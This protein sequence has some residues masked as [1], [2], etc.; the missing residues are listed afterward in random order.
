MAQLTKITT[1]DITKCV[2]LILEQLPEEVGQ[3][4]TFLS[5]DYKIPK[6]QLVCGVLLESQLSGRLSAFML[7]P[8]W[9]EGVKQ[10]TAI[11]KQCHKTFKPDRLGQIYCTEPCAQAAH[12][13]THP[14]LKESPNDRVNTVTI[15]NP[16]RLGGSDTP[17]PTDGDSGWSEIP[18]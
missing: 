10:T 3:T 2:D 1:Q 6:W 15:T 12:L 13:A 4:I 9:N 5:N 7:D 18:A 11:C 8:S 14:E 16:A 17:Q